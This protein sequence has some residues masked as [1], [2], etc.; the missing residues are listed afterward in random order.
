MS[1]MSE[2]CVEIYEL[3]DEGRHPT[4]IAKVLQIPLSMVYDAI[5]TYPTEGNTEVFSPFSTVNS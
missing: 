5:E 2:I 3:L 4:Y 1:R